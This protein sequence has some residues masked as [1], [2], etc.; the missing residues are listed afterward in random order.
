MLAQ[1]IN[2]GFHYLNYYSALKFVF[3]HFPVPRFEYEPLD[4]EVNGNSTAAFSCAVL[5]IR[6]V[7]SIQWYFELMQC[8][9]GITP[10]PGLMDGMLTNDMDSVTISSGTDVIYTRASILLL[11]S[12]DS[13]HE[14]FYRCRVTFTDGQ[15]LCSRNASLIFSSKLS[16]SVSP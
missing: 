16:I 8:G 13:Q 4:L 7:T 5:G 11:E 6:P 2:Y 1:A 15:T 12:V 3:A 14:G 9:S 10:S